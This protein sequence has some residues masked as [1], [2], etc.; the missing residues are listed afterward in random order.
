MKAKDLSNTRTIK[1]FV[2]AEPGAGKT[3]LFA[4]AI[5]CPDLAPLLWIDCGGNSESVR[6][7]LTSTKTPVIVIDSTKDLDSIYD[8]LRTD[9]P[10]KHPLR[11]EV[12]ALGMTLPPKVKTIVLDG[13]TE[14]QRLVI[15]ETVG[16]NSQR[17]SAANPQMQIQQ[18]GVV[19]NRTAKIARLLYGLPDVS[20]FIS[21]L[22]DFHQDSL[23]QVMQFSPMLQ[24]QSR[25]EVPAY[26]LLTTRI[27]RKNKAS[28]RDLKLATDNGIKEG[29]FRALYLFDSADRALAKIQYEGDIPSVLADTSMT[30]IFNYLY[31]KK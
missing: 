25:T 22:E 26:S 24:G 5:E 21:C 29:S 17:I 9:Q 18:W 3:T 12:A 28:T 6:S 23:T 30:E 13:M 1:M 31:P 2:Y 19:L 20:V 8:W 14:M 11:D 10:E 4:T 27:V 7:A 15:D 16:A